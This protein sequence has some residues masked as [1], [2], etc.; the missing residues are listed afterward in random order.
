MSEE[1]FRSGLADLWQL[2]TKVD[3][4]NHGSFGACPIE[5]LNRQTELRF[6]ME[7]DPVNFIDGIGRGL[8][9]DAVVRLSD[10]L[11]ADPNGMAF[12][13]NATTGVNTVLSSLDINESDEVLVTDTTYQACKN[14]VDYHASAKGFSVNVV[15]IGVP[16]SSKKEVIDAFVGQ[17][18]GNTRL[19][20]I[21][22]VA[23]PTGIMTP[24]AELVDVLNHMGVDT[25]LDAAHGPGLIPLDI[26]KLNASFVTG[27]CHKWLCTP[28][29]SAFL[30]VRSDRLDLRPL[31]ISHGASLPDRMGPRFRLEFDWTGT[32]DPTAWMCIP[33]AID[34]LGGLFEGGWGEIMARNNSLALAA[35]SMIMERVGLEPVCSEDFITSMAAFIIPGTPTHPDP[36]PLHER[37]YNLHSIQVP[38]QGWENHS[39]RYLRISAHLYNHIE[40]YERLCEALIHELG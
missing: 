31:V 16:I 26:A 8:W 29:G 20:L 7:S 30:H 34:Y 9:S 22:T 11:N 5:V 10:F 15:K 6:M 40:Q 21:D 39:A 32:L 18:T 17:V 25:L 4:L 19:A 12:V 14:A 37:L 28:K 36:D 23:S 27:N 38:V 35:R 24:F 33:F 1:G 3:F 13:N 2:N